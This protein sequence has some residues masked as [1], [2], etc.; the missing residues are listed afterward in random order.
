MWRTGRAACFDPR[1]LA[2]HSNLRAVLAT[3]GGSL[4]DPLPPET[5]TPMPPQLH[6]VIPGWPNHPEHIPEPED[7][8]GHFVVCDLVCDPPPKPHIRP[9]TNRENVTTHR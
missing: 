2:T 7:H 4:M 3:Q 8:V 1:R 9:H 5:S 6:T